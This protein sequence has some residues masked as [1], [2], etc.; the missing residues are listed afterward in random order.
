MQFISNNWA[1]QLS[2]TLLKNLLNLQHNA[3]ITTNNN[4][5]NFRTPRKIFSDCCVT[6]CQSENHFVDHLWSHKKPICKNRNPQEPLVILATVGQSCV[7]V[8]VSVVVSVCV[9]AWCEE[10][11]CDIVALK[12]LKKLILNHHILVLTPLC[13]YETSCQSNPPSGSSIDDWWIC[14]VW[15]WRC[16]RWRRRSHTC[17]TM[18]EVAPT[19]NWADS[20]KSSPLPPWTQHYLWPYC[21]WG[22]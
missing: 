15:R 5:N 21:W 9:C 16:C 20:G 13:S 19:R 14:L 18:C 10:W 3:C 22:V 2:I 12:S 4:W 6:S 1:L 17:W 8:N 11:C 7:C